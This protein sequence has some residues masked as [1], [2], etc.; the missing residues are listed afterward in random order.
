VA[1][2]IEGDDVEAVAIDPASGTAYAGTFHGVFRSADGGESWTAIGAGLPNT[3]VR[4]L[5]VSGGR[6]WAGTAGGSVWSIELP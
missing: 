1:Q 3:D 4:A 2:G 6:L 5:A